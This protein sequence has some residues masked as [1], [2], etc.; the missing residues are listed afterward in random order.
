MKTGTDIRLKDINA[1]KELKVSFLN[2]RLGHR[3]QHRSWGLKSVDV[4]GE[5]KFCQSLVYCH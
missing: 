3:L 1:P 2:S 4:R 5:F